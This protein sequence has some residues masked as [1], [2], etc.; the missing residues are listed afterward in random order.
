MRIVSKYQQGG[1]LPTYV[2]FTPV[3]A[4]SGATQALAAIGVGSGGA[5]AAA[6]SGSSE[7][8]GGGSGE[9]GAM[10]MLSKS[11]VDQIMKEG[12][13]SDV[14]VFMQQFDAF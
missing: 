12:T 11:M 2:G 13:P 14:K 1:A 4:G 9:K 8:E 6:A 3:T 7:E 10:G 5:T